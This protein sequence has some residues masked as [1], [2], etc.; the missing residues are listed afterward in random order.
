MRWDVVGNL[1]FGTPLG[2]TMG[3]CWDIVVLGAF[4]DPLFG[5]RSG[6]V[7]KVHSWGRRLRI[8]KGTPYPWRSLK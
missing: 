6:V 4:W 5:N 3:Q 8:C 1:F 2:P 7:I